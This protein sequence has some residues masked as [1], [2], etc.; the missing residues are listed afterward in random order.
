MRLTFSEFVPGGRQ[1]RRGRYRLFSRTTEEPIT[2]RELD[3]NRFEIG[4]DAPGGALRLDVSVSELSWLLGQATD[5]A[6][7]RRKARNEQA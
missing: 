3:D 6:N 4:V 2:L 1:D 5:I 7:R